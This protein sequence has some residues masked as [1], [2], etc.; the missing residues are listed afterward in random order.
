LK[1]KRQKVQKSGKKRGKR[2]KNEKKVTK[3]RKKRTGFLRTPLKRRGGCKKTEATKQ[4]VKIGNL[5]GLR[6]EKVKRKLTLNIESRGGAE[7]QR[8]DERQ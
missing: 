3:R 7:A 4:N 8:K 1:K 5:S 2:E 6:R